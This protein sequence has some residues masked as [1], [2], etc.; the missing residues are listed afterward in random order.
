MKQFLALVCV[1]CTNFSLVSYAEP[2][3][4][5]L[6]NPAKYCLSQ[7]EQITDLSN[8]LALYNVAGLVG[9][10]GMGKTELAKKYAYNN[11]DKYDLIWFFNSNTD[12][13]E[14]FVNLSKQ[15]N[16]SKLC[17]ANK[18]SLSED[19]QKAKQD[20]L[21]FLAPKSNWLLVFDNL[22]V[23][24][25]AKIADIVKWQHNGAVIL[26]SQDAK[27]LPNAIHL[28]YLSDNDA[29]NVINVILEDKNPEVVKEL[30]KVAKG[31]PILIVQGTMYLNENKH[32]TVADYE[33]IISA[34]NDKMRSHVEIVLKQLS[35]TT[36]DLLYKIAVINNQQFSRKLLE[37]IVS[38]DNLLKDLDSI[39]RFGL[40]NVTYTDKDNS[41]FEMHDAIK[42]AVLK[43]IGQKEAKNIV[44]KVIDRLNELMPKGEDNKYVSLISD[45]TLKSSLEELLNNA[46][47]Y[48]VSLYKNMELRKNLI[49]LYIAAL[50]YYGCEKMT[51]WLTNRSDKLDSLVSKVLMNAKEKTDYAEFLVSIGV[52]KNRAQNNYMAA[53]YY[54][55]KAANLVNK[56][57]VPELSFIIYLQLARVQG[58][59]GDIGDAESNLQKAY[60]IVDKNTTV[61]F[62]VGALSFVKSKLYLAN[63]K[64]DEALNAINETIKIDNE[65]GVPQGIFTTPVYILKAEGKYKEA[66]EITK[67]LYEQE[68]KN[69]KSNHELLARILTRLSAAEA[70]LKMTNEALEHAEKAIKIF[71]DNNTLIEDNIYSNS[72][73]ID[74]ALAYSTLGNVLSTSIANDNNKEVIINSYSSASRIYYN[75][76]RHNEFKVDDVGYFCWNAAKNLCKLAK[77]KDEEVKVWYTTYRDKLVEN[78]PNHPRT[79]DILGL[80]KAYKCKAS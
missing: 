37:G 38:K 18:C 64:Y 5:N 22:H 11:Q 14:Q 7:E 59:I 53:I 35:N 17:D 21:N 1:I 47:K 32:M 63:G 10:S 69:I 19:T 55:N 42:E 74:L 49:G 80:E 27:D 61:N 67:N 46:E 30:V 13:I 2:A 41:I 24:Q 54:L 58:F 36:K 75:R 23:N 68:H 76:Y 26:C 29:T 4:S 40:V 3:V 51:E 66:Y 48:E 79:K 43:I 56:L 52:Y 57:K 65:A 71:N 15:I 16:K 20:V 44:T 60:D 50:D 70:G 31:Y 8:R 33:K 6:V 9:F 12:L 34:S 28:P 78:W 45:K 73:N 62:D 25:N 39:I 72:Y 77:K